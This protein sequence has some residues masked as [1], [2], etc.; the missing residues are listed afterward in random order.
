MHIVVIGAGVVGLATARELLV[1]GHDVTLVE[2]AAEPGAG[3]SG[4]N[5]AQL[6]YAYVAPLASPGTLRE[7]PHLLLDRDSPLRLQPSLQPGFLSW[8]L[9]FLAACRQDQ[10]VRTTGALLA[11]A[12]LSRARLHEWLRPEQAARIGHRRNGKLVVYR[13]GKAW[14]QARR[15]MELQARLQGPTQQALDARECLAR[16]PALD[17][18]P[19]AGGIYTPGEEVADCGALC[20]TLFDELAAHPRC[21]VHL[22]T[23]VLRWQTAGRRIETAVLADAHG[24]QWTLD[25]EAVVVC[26][27]TGSVPLLAGLG[28]S[29]PLAPLKGYS[30]EI[31]RERLERFPRCSITDSARKVVYAPLGEGHAAR[32]RV[33]GF[34]ELSWRGDP[35]IDL[36][37]I[38]HLKRSAAALFGLRDPDATWDLRPWAG[39]RP[40]TPTGLP[41]IGR[42]RGWDNAFLNTGHGAL[43]LTLAFGSAAL[44]RSLLEGQRAALD[45]APFAQAAVARTSDVFA[46]VAGASR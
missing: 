10:V 23:Q 1:A 27:G 17:G 6:S 30:I 39:L 41:C 4:R 34:A 2:R 46:P 5:G 25:C 19:V 12:A 31:P 11:L 3:A 20:Q 18:V 16:E 15:Q 42:A 37:R 8:G 36:G 29:L 43:G 9:R 35:G 13:S 24:R 22:G 38:E 26:A 7:L 33:A 44:L 32:L 28:V 40:A 45:P 21:R 14:A